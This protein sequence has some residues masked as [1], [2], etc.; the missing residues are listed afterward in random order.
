LR[1]IYYLVKG[2]S[3]VPPFRVYHEM[4]SADLYS[5]GPDFK[6]PIF[7][8]QGAEDERTPAL[9]A[10]EYFEWIN[11]PQ[12]GFVIFDGA[13]DFAALSMIQLRRAPVS[14]QREPAYRLHKLVGL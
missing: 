8:F 7:F 14:I 2:F 3:Q 9:L 12:K 1:D 13:G 6:I 4:L 5:L 11:A 10:K